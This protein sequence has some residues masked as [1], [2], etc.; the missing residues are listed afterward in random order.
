MDTD[1]NRESDRM[2]RLVWRHRLGEEAGRRGPRKKWSVDEVVDAAIEDADAAGTAGVEAVSMRKIAEKLHT[3]AASLYTYIPGRDE[4]LGLMVDQVTGRAELPVFDG[5]ATSATVVVE[6]LRELSRVAWEEIHRHP[7][8]LSAQRHRPLIG[9]NVSERYEWQLAALDG[10]GLD[11]VAM[12]HTVALV[13]SHAV[14]SAAAS[15]NA[16]ELA[17]TSGQSDVEWW[18]ANEPVLSQVMRGDEFPVS[19]R[20]GSAVGERYQAVTD[21]DAVYRYGLEVIL[22]GVRARL[23]GSGGADGV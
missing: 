8:L 2:L 4:L 17:R 6:R 21:P 1:N 3:S 22:D 9:P 19:G 13:E 23:A 16:R 12:D 7:W 14:A 11:D 10:C 18:Q 20:V 5:P 15:V